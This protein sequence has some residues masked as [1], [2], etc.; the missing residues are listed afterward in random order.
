ML[1]GKNTKMSELKIS[2]LIGSENMY[3]FGETYTAR[4][5]FYSAAGSDGQ[6]KSHLCYRSMS[7]SKVI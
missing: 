2:V 6:D 3:Y 4:K 1:T 7:A 5:K